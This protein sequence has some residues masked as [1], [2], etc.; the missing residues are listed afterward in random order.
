MG[1]RR[2]GVVLGMAA[3]LGLTTAGSPIDATANTSPI[4]TLSV[5]TLAVATSTIAAAR[6]SGALSE[7]MPQQPQPTAADPGLEPTDMRVLLSSIDVTVSLLDVYGQCRDED[8]AHEPCMAMI[9]STLGH[10]RGLIGSPAQ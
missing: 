10:A 5:A 1:A 9:R 7:A 4:D 6:P 8:L 2:I 3:S